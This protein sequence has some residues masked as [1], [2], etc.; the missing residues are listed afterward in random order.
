MR[1]KLSYMYRCANGFIYDG[2]KQKQKEHES[3]LR[4]ISYGV[5]AFCV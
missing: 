1:R 4:K 2:K 5:L 3:I